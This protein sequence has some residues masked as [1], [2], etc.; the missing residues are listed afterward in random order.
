[1]KGSLIFWGL[2]ALLILIVPLTAIPLGSG[3]PPAA[4]VAQ[5][6]SSAPTSSLP[7]ESPS[8]REASASPQEE[9]PQGAGVFSGAPASFRVLD[10]ATGQVE[11]IPAAEYVRGA[12]AAEM[13]A[14]YHT[15][16][17]KAQAVAAY[18][19][20]VRMALDRRENPLP[21]LNGA[22]FSADP[23]NRQVYLTEEGAREFYGDYF[24]QYWPKVCQAADEVLGYLLLD[25]E[26]QPVAAAYHAISA[27]VTE[28][29]ANI[30]DGAVP[31]LTPA[32][33][34]GDLLAHDYETTAAFSA[35][36]MR[37]LLETVEGADLSGDPAGWIQI[38]ARSDSG[39]VTQ[40][41]V[42]GVPLHG[43]ELRTLLGLRST[44]FD[45]SADGSAFTFTVRGYGHGAGLSQNGADYMARQGATFDQILAHYYPGSRLALAA[46]S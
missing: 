35:G 40:V 26:G 30:W 12:V 11:E 14:L 33:S 1:M 24:D 39:Y 21:S 16:A 42:G 8:S 15:E 43:Q 29:A 38:A 20:A 34:P 31:C 19:Y 36:E 44:A 46:A 9:D 18:T 25:P 13:P 5:A 17:L 32:Q 45:L 10:Q 7:E 4:S 2:L 22:D 28:D 6:A 27:G 23:Q 37:A 41:T 3:S